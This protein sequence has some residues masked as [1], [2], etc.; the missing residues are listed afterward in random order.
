M[1]L[2]ML[3]EMATSN[4]PD[5]A[6][7]SAHDLALTYQEMYGRAGAGASYLRAGGYQTV[8]Y[9][10]PNSAAFAV[11][12]FAAAWAGIP[13]WPVNYRLAGDQILGLL[14]TDERVLV[15]THQDSAAAVRGCRHDVI[16]VD[17]WLEQTAGA[18]PL[19]QWPSDPDLVAV[20]LNTSGTTSKPKTVVLRHRHLVSYV[21]HSVD[22]GSADPADAVAVSVPP[23]HVA[24]IVNL[25]TNIFAG[26]R[27]V[28]LDAFEPGAWLDTVRRE[29]V[30]HAMVVPTMLARIVAELNGT[31]ANVPS[32]RTLSYGGSRVGATTILQALRLF[33]GTDFVNAYGLTETSS[34]IAIL[35]P[36]D[37]RSAL[38]SDDEVVRARLASAG[39]VI[40][41]VEAEIRS[42]D[43]RPV[44]PGEAG[45]LWLRGDQIS[46]EYLSS[47]SPLDENGWFPTKDRAHFDSAQFLFIEGRADDTIIRGGENI[48]PAEIE[49]VLMQHPAV[50]EAAVVGAPDEE[51]GQK[52]VAFVVLREGAD[53]DA[54]EI[55]SFAR[56]K[57]RTSKTPDRIIERDY[58]PYT[59]SGKLLRRMLT[60][61]LAAGPATDM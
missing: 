8:A 29:R 2:M 47:E 44:P 53:A 1:N 49:D 42:A 30:T 12:V 50:G 22:F 45:E 34:T 18:A 28:Y 27:V 21:L 37:H 6:A 41:G 13:F 54:D 31:P 5:R 57:L 46:G 20:L 15:V 33:P 7:V 24:G 32:L 35:S 58:L 10:G 4:D 38:H 43:G 11:T 48:A 52:I 59:D 17:Q 14:D 23:Y 16:S 19:S 3:L 56:G 9:L 36:E 61:E 40:P 51:W 55:R 25:L 39:Q 26:R 60:A